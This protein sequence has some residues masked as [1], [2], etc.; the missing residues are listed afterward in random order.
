MGLK[1]RDRSLLKINISD[2]EK[3]PFLVWQHKYYTPLALVLG[4]FLP[5]TIC[6]LFWGDW[7]GGFFVAGIAARVIILH[8]TFC[9]NSVAHTLGNYSFNDQQSPRDHFLTS[10]ITFGEGY[11]NFHHEFPNDYRNGVSWYDYD[12]SKWGIALAELFG[13]AFNLKRIP[14]ELIEKGRLAMQQKQLDEQKSKFNWGTPVD[15]L[16]TVTW[17]E[18]NKDETETTATPCDGCFRNFVVMEGIVYNVS[19]FLN[20]HPGGR[21]ILQAH[22][23]KDV[24]AAFNGEVYNHSLCAR[25]ILAK[26]RVAKILL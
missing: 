25:H 8:C 7:R 10:L 18:L 17:D 13:V 4:L 23:G 5:M 24:T 19:T 14:I 20:E 16:P 3:D 12:P 9:V 22:L 11:H 21:T 26:F 15:E 2:L 1:K 6:G